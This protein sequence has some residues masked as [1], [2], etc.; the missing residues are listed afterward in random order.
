MERIATFILATD[1]AFST[2]AYNPLLLGASGTAYSRFSREA[3]MGD[4]L[5]IRCAEQEDAPSRDAFLE[6]RRRVEEAIRNG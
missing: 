1:K 5:K 2:K 3:A 6:L 4:A